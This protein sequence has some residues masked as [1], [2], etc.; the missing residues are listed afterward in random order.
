MIPR[1]HLSSPAFSP[2]V[3]K[4]PHKTMGLF[5]RQVRCGRCG[6]C[7]RSAKRFLFGTAFA[8]TSP[9]PRNR[10]LLAFT[11]SIFTIH[12]VQEYSNVSPPPICRAS[13]RTLCEPLRARCFLRS[14]K[15][16]AAI[17]GSVSG[18][19]ACPVLAVTQIRQ[20]VDRFYT[21]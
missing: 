19:P 6:R 21:S 12:S 3:E 8:A 9:Q 20:L 2:G 5:R 4:A 18:F 7:E 10:L 11:N 17:F 1:F 16:G 14:V 15:S 13:I